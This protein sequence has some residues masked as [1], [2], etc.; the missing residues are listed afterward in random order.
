MQHHHN[1]Y[2]HLE[3]RHDNQPPNADAPTAAK[4]KKE[5]NLHPLPVAST[6]PAARPDTLPQAPPTTTPPLQLWSLAKTFNYLRCAGKHHASQDP[7]WGNTPLSF[8]SASSSPWATPTSKPQ[9]S[10]TKQRNLFEEA[11]GSRRSNRSGSAADVKK[12]KKE[13]NKREKAR[14]RFSC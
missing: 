14:M 9:P 8:R 2:L 12:R 4:A 10:L 3:I 6:A 7:H 13:N 5:N 11:G 1:N